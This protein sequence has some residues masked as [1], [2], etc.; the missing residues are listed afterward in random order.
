[1]LLL[2]VSSEKA[3]LIPEGEAADSWFAM[4]GPEGTW[5]QEVEGMF[6]DLFLEP[7]GRPRGRAVGLV[8]ADI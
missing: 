4:R 5:D 2:L 6:L 8:G 1:V 3:P 7:S